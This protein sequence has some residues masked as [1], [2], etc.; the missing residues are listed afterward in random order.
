MK[1]GNQR[2][3]LTDGATRALNQPIMHSD[4]ILPSISGLSESPPAY[5]ILT[6]YVMGPSGEWAARDLRLNLAKVEQYHEGLVHKGSTCLIFESGNIALCC[7]AI[8]NYERAIA[9]Y[10]EYCKIAIDPLTFKP[11]FDAAD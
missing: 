2:N 10:R 6:C 5:I 9:Q 7:L 11:T 1:K 4:S 3:S 8:E